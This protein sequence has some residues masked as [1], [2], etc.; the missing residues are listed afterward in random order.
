M[1]CALAKVMD[2]CNVEPREATADF[3][4]HIFRELNT[5]ADALAGRHEDSA[6]LQNYARPAKFVRAFFDGS[7]KGT[8]TAYGWKVFATNDVASDSLGD[9][10]PVATRCGVLPGHAS[11]T[12]AELEGAASLV[13]FLEAYYQGHSVAERALRKKY[14][15]DHTAIH[16]LQLAD[17]V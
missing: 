10:H 15:V 5:D 17:L 7:C 4:R 1:H 8:S 11:V 16:V 2:S 13:G 14:Y 6:W 12:A 9:W 3:G